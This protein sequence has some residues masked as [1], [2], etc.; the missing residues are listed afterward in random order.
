MRAQCM[1]VCRAWCDAL[2]D[3]SL[4]A[5]LHVQPRSNVQYF[6]GRHDVLL[7][8][9]VRRYEDVYGAV[10]RARGTLR[11]LTISGDTIS[12]NEVTAKLLP[13]VAA[14]V[15]TL[16]VLSFS[17]NAWEFAVVAAGDAPVG[18]VAVSKLW[19]VQAAAARRPRAQ[20]MTVSERRAVAGWHPHATVRYSPHSALRYTQRYED[21]RMKLHS[22]QLHGDEAAQ[23]HVLLF[24]VHTAAE[25]GAAACDEWG[26]LCAPLPEA[27]AGTAARA[28]AAEIE[29]HASL[30]RLE[31]R[32][33]MLDT[34]A[35]LGAI[36]AA[37]HARRLARL[38]LHKCNVSVVAMPVLMAL[39]GSASALRDFSFSHGE[40]PLD[41]DS[42][43]A[44]G[45]SVHASS[46]LSGFTLCGARGMAPGALRR[47]VQR[48]FIAHSSLRKL[49]LLN[50]RSGEAADFAGCVDAGVAAQLGAMLAADA[51]ALLELSIDCRSRDNASEAAMAPLFTALAYNTH[52]RVLLFQ[53]RLLREAFAAG[54]L[55]PALRANN[56]LRVLGLDGEH[57]V[58]AAENNRLLNNAPSAVEARRLVHRRAVEAFM[59]G[60][61]TQPPP[62]SYELPH[63]ELR[64]PA[65]RH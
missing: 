8:K 32:H 6:A 49:E 19:R 16:R 56:A 45:D 9:L 33:C 53:N 3:P 12:E 17:G 15:R 22:A 63:L 14:N 21:E 44:L 40:L 37:V 54:A 57:I 58:T 34:P 25:D 13:L 42:A 50:S 30:V 55:L 60:V 28:L 2:G 5:R 1:R 29:T 61:V 11:E 47:L 23:Q 46:A 51:P 36:V 35:T 18:A 27:T 64:M 39:F 65:R 10:A 38:E 62:A 4:W 43:A 59:F 31:L 48:G 26:T 20:R 24:Y 7:Y 52:L 41:E